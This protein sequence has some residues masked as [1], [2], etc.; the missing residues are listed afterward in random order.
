MKFTIK[1][2][3]VF[4]VFFIAS[5]SSCYHYWHF[6]NIKEHN[7]S[8]INF[9]TDGVYFAENRKNKSHISFRYLFFYTDGSVYC[10]EGATEFIKWDWDKKKFD[11]LNDENYNYYKNSYGMPWLDFGA[12]IIK[13]S[14]IKIQRFITSD[15][16]FF[17]RDIINTFFVIKDTSTIL[18]NYE[19]CKFCEEPYKKKWYNPPIEYNF[20]KYTKV[21][22][23]QAWFKKKRWYK[24]AQ[25]QD[26]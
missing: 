20:H 22:S 7:N 8:R 18:L 10:G 9:K 21:D 4:L 15:K 5:L 24:N 14:I 6:T 1:V 16:G 11:S 25:K 2:F 12:Y 19:E 13:D 23:S 3:L 17:S 26:H